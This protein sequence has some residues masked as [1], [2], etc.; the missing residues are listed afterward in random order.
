MSLIFTSASGWAAEPAPQPTQRLWPPTQENKVYYY[1]LSALAAA[2][3]V[4]DAFIKETIPV[5]E[6]EKKGIQVWSER[7]WKPTRDYIARA[8]ELGIPKKQLETYRNEYREKIY[9]R[10]VGL[11][12]VTVM[13]G[14]MAL[15]YYGY[16]PQSAQNT[17][18]DLD[19]KVQTSSQEANPSN[20]RA[21]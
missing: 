19:E 8:Q 17:K 5:N 15:D 21:Y 12:G 11:A 16:L 1:A 7:S 20:S 6:L 2:R 10:G 14:M 9:G 13:L 4:Y 3:G 18:K